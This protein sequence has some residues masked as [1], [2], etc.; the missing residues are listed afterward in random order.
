MRNLARRAA[1]ALAGRVMQAGR[2]AD[3]LGTPGWLIAPHLLDLGW[4]I[5][6]LATRGVPD[7]EGDSL[8]P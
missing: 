5:A 3:R 1:L 4:W 7:P 6:D 8:A 2:I